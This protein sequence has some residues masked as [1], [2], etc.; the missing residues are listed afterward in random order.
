MSHAQAAG[1]SEKAKWFAVDRLVATG[2]WE[3]CTAQ[4]SN[5][6]P[7]RWWPVEAFSYDLLTDRWGVGVFRILSG[8]QR[9]RQWETEP[10]DLRPAGDSDGDD[11][12]PVADQPTP[13]APEVPQQPAQPSSTAPANGAA[14][15]HIAASIPLPPPSLPLAFAPPPGAPESLVNFTYIE[16]LSHRRG[17]EHAQLLHNTMQLQLASIEARNSENLQSAR[18]FYAAMAMGQ[19][20]MQKVMVEVAKQPSASPELVDALARLGDGQQ[21]MAEAIARLD[22]EPEGP[23]LEQLAM[24][25][26]QQ[27]SEVQQF[28]EKIAPI[29]T[30]FIERLL[31]VDGTQQPTGEAAPDA[32]AAE[33]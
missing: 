13:V 32:A 16:A 26:Q 29:A 18:E 8:S 28:L 17:Q 7:Q 23:D 19:E 22:E 6:R 2:E 24:Q 20:R 12:Q 30:P 5:G 31:Q 33:E 10:I 4:S 21:K 3:E 15:P 14:H 25:L 11:A 9:R 1:I 27:P